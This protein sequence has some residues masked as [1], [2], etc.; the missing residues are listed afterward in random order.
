[1]EQ[2]LIGDEQAGRRL[3]YDIAKKDYFYDIG[4]N[5]HGT[6][7]YTNTKMWLGFKVN[8]LHEISAP[9]VLYYSL[10]ESSAY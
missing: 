1:M 4:R 5:E 6:V 9:T 8:I 7:N 10:L 3:D 2:F